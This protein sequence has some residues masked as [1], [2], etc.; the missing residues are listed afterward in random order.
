METISL[1]A[2]RFE[3]VGNAHYCQN[4][5]PKTPRQYGIIPHIGGQYNHI[6]GHLPLLC[7]LTVIE[8]FPTLSNR[9]RT[10]RVINAFFL[11]IYPRLQ[12]M[13]SLMITAFS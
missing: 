6:H 12:L 7:S 9:Q 2:P 4:E 11:Y 8:K 5:Q 10:K 3:A 1:L 13:I